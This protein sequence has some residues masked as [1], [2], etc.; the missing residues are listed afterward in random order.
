[1]EYEDIMHMAIDRRVYEEQRLFDEMMRRKGKEF[2]DA[3]ADQIVY[4]TGVMQ[5]PDRRVQMD[6]KP[7]YSMAEIVLMDGTTQT[8]MMKASTSIIGHLTK[9]MKE[10]G[11]LTMWNDTD[12]LC[13]RADQVKQFALRA[14][15]QQE[16]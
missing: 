14:F 6:E 13:I 2:E 10:K 15:T 11:F 9:E 5:K 8:F 3:L 12:V 1:M 4:G 16:K 7:Q